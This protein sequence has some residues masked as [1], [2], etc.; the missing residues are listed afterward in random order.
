MRAATRSWASGLTP[1]RV[2]SRRQLVGAISGSITI[3]RF[4]VQGE[5]PARYQDRFLKSIRLRAMQPLTADCEEEERVGWCV[6]GDALDLDLSAQKL[7]SETAVTLGFRV[8]KWSIPRALFNAHFN[9]AKTLKLA[10]TGRE[11]LTKREKD[12]LKFRITRKLKRKLI[13][14]TRHSDVV[15]LVDSGV[16]WFWN[17]SARAKED[18]TQLFEQTFSLT[19]HEAS[20]FIVARELVPAPRLEGASQIE[21]SSVQTSKETERG[22]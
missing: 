1:E 14:T 22:E 21:Q 16:L 9:E 19:L 18:L 7:F 10:Q 5:L 4:F 11:K 8:D 13:P 12:E 2:T 17:R 20:P 6:P 15:W 3:S